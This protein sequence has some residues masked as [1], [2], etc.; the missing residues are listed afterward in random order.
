MRI[1]LVLMFA[2]GAARR[3]GFVSSVWTSLLQ[4]STVEDLVAAA[5]DVGVSYIEL[6]QGEASGLSRGCL[7]SSVAS[8]LWVS[9]GLLLMNAL[10][11]CRRLLL[12]TLC[13]S[14]SSYCR[15]ARASVRGRQKSV[16]QRHSTGRAGPALPCFDAELRVPVPVHVC[17]GGRQSLHPLH[18][19][20]GG[21]KGSS[22][23]CG[24]GSA[25]WRRS[26]PRFILARLLYNTLTRQAEPTHRCFLGHQATVKGFCAWLM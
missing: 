19:C 25:N 17:P 16:A 3:F 5:R 2:L 7:L 26:I 13:R 24:R 8:R 11:S 22:S 20:P 18:K 23:T 1:L 21:G 15:V 12:G 10:V 6:R 4:N 9:H 14:C